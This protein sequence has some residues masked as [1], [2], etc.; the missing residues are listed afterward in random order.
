MILFT[1]RSCSSVNLVVGVLVG[2]G[3][4]GAVPVF[5]F[6]QLQPIILFLYLRLYNKYIIIHLKCIALIMNCRFFFV[7]LR[8]IRIC[9]T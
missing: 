6:L 9:K 3:V 2:G 4:G 5:D 1:W 7:F 8:K